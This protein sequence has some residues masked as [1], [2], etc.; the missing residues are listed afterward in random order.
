MAERIETDDP[1][2]LSK[3]THK[4]HVHDH[5]PTYLPHSGP[6]KTHAWYRRHNK[7]IPLTKRQKRRL[8]A[9][10]EI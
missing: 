10:K 7:A 2:R 1:R 5:K 3:A 4:G 8:L 9:G 6:A